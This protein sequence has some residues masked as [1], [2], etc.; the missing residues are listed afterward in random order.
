MKKR[1]SWLTGRFNRPAS[2]GEG[3][4][5]SKEQETGF[6]RKYGQQLQYTTALSTPQLT[7]RQTFGAAWR[8]GNPYFTSSPQ[9]HRAR[10]LASGVAGLTLGQVGLAI[11]LN[12]WRGGFWDSMVTLDPAAFT[13]SIGE[14]AVVAGL[15]VG[16]SVYRDYL[17]ALLQVGWRDWMTKDLK[18]KWLDGKTAYR[19]QKV[20]DPMNAPD[21]RLTTDII[22]FLWKTHSLSMSFLHATTTLAMF[23]GILWSLGGAL[24]FQVGGM[25]VSVPGY[26]VGIALAFAGAA[27][28]GAQMIGK[29]LPLIHT[30][31]ERYEADF[32]YALVRLRENSESVALY[33]G[34]KVENATLTR[35]FNYLVGNLYQLA[36]KNR[37][38]GFLNTAFGKAGE[39]VPLVAA[40]PR[41][42]AG[43][44]T[45]GG[46]Q[47][48]AGAFGH[49]VGSLSW[50]ASVYPELAQ[51]R[52][53]VARL[54]KFHDDIDR[55]RRSAGASIRR[56]I[57][58]H[59][60]PVTFDLKDITL[61]RPQGG[62]TL[63]APFSLSLRPGDRLALTG[64][65]GSGKSS[66]I[67]AVSGLWDDGSGTVEVRSKAGIL[68]VP[69]KP[70]LP[71]ETLRGIIC[72]PGSPDDFTHEQVIDAMEAAGLKHYAPLLDE[73]AMEGNYWA[74]VLSGGEQQRIG[75]ARIFL[76]KPDVLMLDEVTSSM[77][78]GAEQELYARVI[79]KLPATI[80]ISIAHREKVLQFHTI[81]G[82]IAEQKFTHRPLGQP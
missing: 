24:D 44:L 63:F 30:F 78:P 36:R 48:V 31:R 58:T 34:E 19:L 12:S 5:Q 55:S 40:S 73:T 62:G 42:F 60:G 68:V 27:T 33:S 7:L 18:E 9:R 25:D 16:A 65:V 22:D 76:H 46:M 3:E 45:I 59:D 41:L 6:A 15:W 72:Y 35:K 29:P 37:D 75:F 17:G 54:I 50:M 51:Y 52:A 43:E 13:A 23:S 14:F 39:V 67:R 1:W 70:Y 56:D 8:M 28:W 20:S 61:N 53:T 81:H 64:V 49:V 2:P 71:L 10:L 21:Q 4:G 57:A 26:M 69:Q 38:L 77:D 11:W 74:Q 82:H 66:L 32:R 80:I 79:E 47:Q